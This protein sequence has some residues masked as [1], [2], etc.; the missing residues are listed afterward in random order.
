VERITLQERPAQGLGQRMPHGRLAGAADVHQYHDH[1][2]A[3]SF[4]PARGHAL[5]GKAPLVSTSICMQISR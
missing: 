1:R 2:R 4:T 5:S 3:Q